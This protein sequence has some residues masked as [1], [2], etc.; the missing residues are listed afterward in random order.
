MAHACGHRRS[1]P[2]AASRVRTG[3]AEAV[4]SRGSGGRTKSLSLAAIVRPV[5]DSRRFSWACVIGTSRTVH[6]A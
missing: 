6:A 4:G 2:A 3:A 5:L 1:P